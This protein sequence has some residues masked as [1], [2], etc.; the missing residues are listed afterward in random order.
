[1]LKKKSKAADW[2]QGTQ[3]TKCSRIQKEMGSATL[4]NGILEKDGPKNQRELAFIFAKIHPREYM[5]YTLGL[6]CFRQVYQKQFCSVH[7]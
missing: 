4:S 5:L 7:S 2:L 3:E 1:M 6:A